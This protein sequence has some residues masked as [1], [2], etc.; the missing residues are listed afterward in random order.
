[1]LLATKNIKCVGVR[2]NKERSPIGGKIREYTASDVTTGWPLLWM[3]NA[4][5]YVE[6][7]SQGLNSMVSDC[8]RCSLL[9]PL[10]LL[11]KCSWHIRND[12]A[13]IKPIMHWFPL[14][15]ET[16]LQDWSKPFCQLLYLAL[17]S[18]EVS[19][20]PLFMTVCGADV[21]L[22]WLTQRSSV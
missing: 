11:C 3:H 18:L 17:P 8:V 16:Q 7:S 10:E 9:A 20:D 19:E 4:L 22:V 2:W 21:T 5:S 13:C 14:L 12:W 6:T 1:M 15:R